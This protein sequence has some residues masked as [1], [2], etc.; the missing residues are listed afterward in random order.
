MDRV[1]V[2]EKLGEFAEWTPHRREELS[3][4]REEL[5]QSQNIQGTSERPL[6]LG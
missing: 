5:E 4:L 2:V 3:R 6:R 1:G